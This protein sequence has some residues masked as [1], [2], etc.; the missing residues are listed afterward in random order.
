MYYLI[1]SSLSLLLLITVAMIHYGFKY[2]TIGRIISLLSKSLQK[3]TVGKIYHGLRK[4]NSSTHVESNVMLRSHVMIISLGILLATLVII[5]NSTLFAQVH[6][7]S[8]KATDIMDDVKGTSLCLHFTQFVQLFVGE[9]FSFG[10][11]PEQTSVNNPLL[12]SDTNIIYM[13][14]LGGLNGKELIREWNTMV[15]GNVNTGEQPIIGRYQ[16][17]DQLI[18]GYECNGSNASIDQVC[19]GLNELILTYVLIADEINEKVNQNIT[20]FW[21]TFEEYLDFYSKTNQVTATLFIFLDIFVNYA[22]SDLTLGGVSF[23]VCIVSVIVVLYLIYTAMS[24]F[25]Q[26]EAQIR[27]M[28]NYIPVEILDSTESLRIFSLFNALPSRIQLKQ[29]N[30]RMGDQDRLK[31]V[32]NATIDGAIL[33]NQKGDIEVFNPSAQRMFGNQ[34]SDVLG[35]SLLALFDFHSE[36]EKKNFA[37]II[38]PSGMLVETNEYLEIE[39]KRKNGTKFPAKLNLCTTYGGNKEEKIITCFLKDITS[40]KKQ[41]IL[42]EEEKKKSENLLLNIFPESVAQKLKSVSN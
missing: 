41:N 38:N 29:N 24:K 6:I 32:L 8:N 33:C 12:L 34:Q 14:E 9:V 10:I 13:H 39:C 21:E 31:N 15:F 1:T 22:A 25:W 37:E 20:S 11:L 19:L 42:L 36:I 3:D 40:E 4:N 30:S 7:S 18:Q 35:L 5:C 26:E 23:S 28:F 17:V 2:S 27:L 16:K